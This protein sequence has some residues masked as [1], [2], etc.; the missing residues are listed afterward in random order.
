MRVHKN[1]QNHCCKICEKK[2]SRGDQCRKHEFNCKIDKTKEL[3]CCECQKEFA[4]QKSLKKHKC[5]SNPDPSENQVFKYLQCGKE[6]SRK[7]ALKRHIEAI[8]DKEDKDSSCTDS[9]YCLP[10]L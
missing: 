10:F 7:D 6:F 3:K 8:Q 2:F 4:S 9:F 1:I 5:K